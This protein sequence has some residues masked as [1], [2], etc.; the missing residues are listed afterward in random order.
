MRA[1]A[2]DRYGG[3]EVLGWHELPDPLPEP[4]E[5]VVRV[6]VCG[7][8]HSDL[9]SRAGTSRWTF[10]LPWVLGAEFSGTIVRT[11]E[12]V[13]GLEPGMPVT[14]SQQFACGSCPACTRW[15]QDLCERF[16]VFG[17]DRWG[18]YGEL[19]A[20]PA[21]AVLPLA[22]E[23]DAIPAAAAQTVVSTAW[24]MVSSLARVRPNETVLVPSASG[25][26]GGALVQ[27]ARLAGARVIATV[28]GAA[29]RERVAALG[30]EAVI[31][32]Q[33]EPV[34]ERVRELTAGEGV[35]AVLDTVGGPMFAEHLGCLRPD[36]RLA[37][38][39]AHAGEVVDLDIVHLFQT[40]RRILG[41]R[42]ATPDEIRTAIDLVTSGRVNVPID[43]SF[44][45]SKAGEAHGYLES[46]VHVGKVLLTAG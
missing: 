27:C 13:S 25:G 10:E 29:K 5:V 20:V 39:G 8:N 21:R 9:D 16:E 15:R 44:P 41:F 3:P 34:G 36:G 7:L 14:A 46:R 42:V 31:D 17:T 45:L 43:R 38:C 28:G 22:G 11:G 32:H 2:F 23:A 26:V 24:H 33:A 35:D 19:V 6:Q 1:A 30:A 40:G 18:G 37:T 4:D 12:A